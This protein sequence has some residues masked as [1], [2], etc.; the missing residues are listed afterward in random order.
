VATAL[1]RFEGPQCCPFDKAKAKKKGGVQNMSVDT[2]QHI[3]LAQLQEDIVAASCRNASAAGG[4]LG[5]VVLNYITLP[6]P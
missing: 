4:G 3:P 6:S 1:L 2:N 5:Y